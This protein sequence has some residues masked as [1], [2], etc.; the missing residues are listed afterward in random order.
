MGCYFCVWLIP[1]AAISPENANSWKLPPYLSFPALPSVEEEGVTSLFE[2]EVMVT[3]VIPG[4]EGIPSG[5]ETTVEMELST[6]IENQTAWGTEVF[7]TDISLL[8]G[9]SGAS[10][11]LGSCLAALVG[12]GHS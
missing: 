7:P 8:S 11:S 3:Q 12:P 4:V 1:Y 10:P 6:E 2:E 5:E 9:G